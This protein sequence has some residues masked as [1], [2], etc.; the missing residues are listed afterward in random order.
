VVADP[1]TAILEVAVHKA[2]HVLDT[3][4]HVLA[5]LSILEAESVNVVWPH[6]IPN[7]NWMRPGIPTSGQRHFGNQLLADHKFIALPGAVST[8][9]WNLI[10]DPA[11]AAGAYQFQTQERFALDTRLNPITSTR[12]DDGCHPTWR[13]CQVMRPRS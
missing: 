6:A 3:T 8:H 13:R 12:F 5:S 7:A 2:F 9:S 4:P 1:A 11:R 10:F